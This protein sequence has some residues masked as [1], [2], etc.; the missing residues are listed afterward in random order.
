MKRL[1]LFPIKE[2]AQIVNPYMLELAEAL[3]KQFQVVNQ[4]D[5]IRFGI[6][7]IL[8]Y[9][10]KI[11]VVYL[12]WIEEI[13]KRRFGLIQTLFLICLIRY[14]KSAG[15][16]I[17]WTLHN[18]RSHHKKR[19]VISDH[20]FMLLL[21][22]SDLIITHAKEGMDLIGDPSRSVFIHHPVRS[23]DQG[24]PSADTPA[25]DILIWGIIEKYKGID[26]F[27]E[28]LFDR[29]VLDKYRI[30]LAGRVASEDLLKK[31]ESLMAYSE[32]ITL[33]NAFV[34]EHVIMSLIKKTKLVVLTYHSESV[35]SSGVLMDSLSQSA[36]IIGPETGAFSDLSQ[37]GLIDTFRDYKQLL[38]K[39]EMHLDPD[40]DHHEQKER[41][42]HFIK[43]NT[44]D[45]FSIRIHDLIEALMQPVS[46]IKR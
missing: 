38:D 27:L 41:I 30:V 39:I 33:M 15:I 24:T 12:N 37:L 32:Q 8:K 29:G 7:Q 11:D 13:P 46:A 10:R 18:K 16:I 22:Q 34:P 44:W 28:Y 40:K 23:I 35:L 43:E 26:T 20:I 45:D 21:K 14:L 2:S 19:R 3:R 36:C 25:S 31:I 17:V 9:I 42:E 4:D 6:I 1:Y 5:P